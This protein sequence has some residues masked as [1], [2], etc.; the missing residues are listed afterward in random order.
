MPTRDPLKPDDV[1]KAKQIQ[2]K[3]IERGDLWVAEETTSKNCFLDDN[4][5]ANNSNIFDPDALKNG[6]SAST[7][8]ITPLPISPANET[9]TAPKDAAY[10]VESDFHPSVNPNTL[11]HPSCDKSDDLVSLLK[12]HIV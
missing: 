3:I 7:P 5:P 10:A 8:W 1:Q 2:Y 12:V 6:R 9:D 4:D 11:M